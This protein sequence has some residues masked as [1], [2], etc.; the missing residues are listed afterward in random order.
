MLSALPTNATV[1]K[2]AEKDQLRIEMGLVSNRATAERPLLR[3]M[4][5]SKV[6]PA[7]RAVL[8]TRLTAMLLKPMV[9]SRRNGTIAQH[10]PSTANNGL[11]RPLVTR[12]HLPSSSTP[13]HPTF[14]SRLRKVC[15]LTPEDCR[16]AT[17]SSEKQSPET[18]VYQRS[19][20]CLADWVKAKRISRGGRG[21][22][23]ARCGERRGNGAEQYLYRSVPIS[24]VMSRLPS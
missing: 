13:S 1:K 4:L 24:R 3:T 22:V 23:L 11:R 8:Q 7:G 14:H 12:R 6:S 17:L 15:F 18:H 16:H 19:G 5:M 2:V 10:S 9:P 20:L 21:R